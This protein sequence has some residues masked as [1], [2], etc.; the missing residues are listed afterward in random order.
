MNAQFDRQVLAEALGIAATVAAAR[1]PKP[2]LQ[3]LKIETAKDIA[4]ISATDLEL[5]IRHAIKHVEV[6][7]PGEVVVRAET[8]TQIVK[9]CHDETLALETVKNNLHIRGKGSHFQIVTHDP[10]EFPP[11]AQME[12]SADF[13]IE[14]GVLRRMIE[15]T[16]Y[17]SARESSRYAI[18]G[19]LWELAG[20]HL[21]LVATDGRRLAYARGTVTAQASGNVPTTIVPSRAMKL[22]LQLVANSDEQVGVKMTPNQF[23]INAGPALISGAVVDGHFPD[24]RKVMPEKSTKLAT[25]KTGEFQGALRQAALLTSEESRAVRLTFGDG[26]LLLSSRAPEQGESSITL[27]VKYEGE[28]IDIGFNPVF[29]M[30][31]LR[32]ASTDEINFGLTEPNRPGLLQTG[33]DFQYVIM[34]VSLSA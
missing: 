33:P 26:S 5:S 15:W 7:K 32:V 13:T 18:N 4:F 11:V 28:P 14:L 27:P 10:Q 34:P 12:G 23:L 9:E 31:V 3:C 25:I 24:Y 17:A 21:T 30:D 1:T 8:L 29:L 6:R 22:L 2:I 20:E 16:N 19:V